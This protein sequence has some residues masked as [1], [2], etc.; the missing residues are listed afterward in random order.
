MKS[1]ANNNNLRSKVGTL[2]G[3]TINVYAWN[4]EQYDYIS[5]LYLYIYECDYTYIIKEKFIPWKR[6]AKDVQRI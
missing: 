4:N 2:G 6:W 3:E 5:F 1:L